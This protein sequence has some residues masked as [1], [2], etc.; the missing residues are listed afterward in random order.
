[1][2]SRLYQQQADAAL[3]DCLATHNRVLCEIFTGGGKTYTMS[4]WIHHTQGRH[5]I[6]V[7]GDDLINQLVES[8]ESMTGEHVGMEKA[9]ITA[10]DSYS[11]VVVASV[12]SL[13]KDKRLARY[14]ENHFDYVHIDEAHMACA[15]GYTKI[16]SHFKAKMILWTAT[17]FRHDKKQLPF[18]HV[19]FRYPYR[20]AVKDGWAVPVVFDRVPLRIDA[21]GV[22]TSKGDFDL[23]QLDHAIEPYLE[24][25]AK[26][27]ASR[28]NGKHL[29][30]LPLIN[31][32]LKMT[33]ILK[34]MGM[35]PYHVDGKTEG[36]K[37]I[38]DAFKSGE[39]NVLCNAQV[40]SVGTDIPIADHLTNLRLTKSLTRYIQTV[41]RVLRPLTE[42]VPALNA[43][44]DPG[45][46]RRIIAESAKPYATVIDPLWLTKKMDICTPP[47]LVAATEKEA[48]LIRQEYAA[49]GKINL[50]KALVV[51]E[52]TIKNKSNLAK[53]LEKNA[54]NKREIDSV[55]LRTYGVDLSE[56]TPRQAWER[57]AITDKQVAWF[58]KQGI[59]Y[60]GFNK[61]MANHVMNSIIESDKP[62]PAMVNLLKKLGVNANGMNKDAA[63][64]AIDKKLNKFK[65]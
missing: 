45:I 11:R 41:G 18:D 56:Y 38:V 39:Y 9:G 55:G 57:D 49:T 52:E 2:S 24:A 7:T 50:S 3:T 20:D 16:F 53:E 23:G 64:A 62:S 19:A 30:F 21:R 34:S 26:E 31:T 37:S 15:D 13:A 63:S 35:R 33:A 25:C 54:N 1:M 36:R 10:H 6:I 47:E 42:I 44:Q 61:G 22:G 28:P 43:E 27:I 8:A 4:K 65:K 59:A 58:K 14:L 48:Q 5:L 51:A 17:P 46:R 29:V 60:G 32:S 12:P 40:F